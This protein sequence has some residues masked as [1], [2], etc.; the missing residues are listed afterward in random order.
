MKI[1]IK[2]SPSQNPQEVATA[3]REFFVNHKAW[4]NCCY[5]CIER[6]ETQETQYIELAKTLKEAVSSIPLFLTTNNPDELRIA[7]AL[8]LQGVPIE[9]ICVSKKLFP[10]QQVQIKR[11]LK[12]G[13]WIDVWVV[14]NPLRACELIQMGVHAI[15]SDRLEVLQMIC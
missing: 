5:F 7:E 9:G 1:D 8:F 12:R 3:F 15:T 11:L 10:D 6:G 14:N 4:Q 2:Y 13:L